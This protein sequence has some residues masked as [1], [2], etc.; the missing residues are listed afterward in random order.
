MFR[1]QRLRSVGTRNRSVGISGYAIPSPA[2]PP[3]AAFALGVHPTLCCSDASH[4]VPCNVGDAVQTYKELVSGLWFTQATSGL[5]PIM[6][7]AGN[8]YY[9]EFSGTNNFRFSGIGAFGTS[10]S[11]GVAMQFGVLTRGDILS[12]W[13]N[14]ADGVS[15]FDVI[16]GNP[17]NGKTNFYVS[18]GAAKGSNNGGGGAVYSTGTDY[19]IIGN[20]PET[21]GTIKNYVNGTL[22]SSLSGVGTLVNSAATDIMVGNNTGLNGAFTGR[23]YGAA[24][25]TSVQ[26]GGSLTAFDLWLRGLQP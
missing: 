21:A 16:T 11:V 20:Y 3:G 24:I 7:L 12:R 18:D 26:T 6:R 2:A 19:R 13:G 4:L 9:L 10:I 5:R 14:G 23:F 25:Y 17:T 1:I 22:D 15:V 8:K